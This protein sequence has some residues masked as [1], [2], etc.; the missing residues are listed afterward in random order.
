MRGDGKATNELAVRQVSDRGRSGRGRGD[1]GETLVEILATITILGI[2]GV[3]ILS[4]IGTSIR[5]S[6]THRTQANMDVALVAATE[7]VK[8]YTP[9][10]APTCLTLSITSYAGALSSLSGLPTGWSAANVSITSATCTTVNGVSLPKIGVRVT[11]PGGTASKSID[12]VRRS[13][14]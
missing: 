12:V 7:A 9:V 2:A 4:G 13:L 1:I 14:V 3:A 11:A 8:S 10:L 5:L 6:G